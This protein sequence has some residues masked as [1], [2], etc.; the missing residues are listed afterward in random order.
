MTTDVTYLSPAEEN[1]HREQNHKASPHAHSTA[2][3]FWYNKKVFAAMYLSAFLGAFC[4]TPH[5]GL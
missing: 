2:C 5:T 1:H 3:N 4:V